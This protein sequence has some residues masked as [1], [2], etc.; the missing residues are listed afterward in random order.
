MDLS[1]QNT[2]KWLEVELQRLALLVLPSAA[3]QPLSITA[4]A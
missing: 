4:S 3:L 2:K 1:P